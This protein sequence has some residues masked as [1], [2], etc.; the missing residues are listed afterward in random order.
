MAKSTFLCLGRIF[1]C[2]FVFL[3]IEV[4]FL[5]FQFLYFIS[6]LL[7]CRK[8]QFFFFFLLEVQCTLRTGFQRGWC[9]FITKVFARTSN[10]DMTVMQVTSLEKKF[11]LSKKMY[12]WQIFLKKLFS[13]SLIVNYRASIV[14]IF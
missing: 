12:K 9:K 10:K 14:L 11:I 4:L 1:L 3:E 2:R 6:I 7:E 5:W 13:C 8:C